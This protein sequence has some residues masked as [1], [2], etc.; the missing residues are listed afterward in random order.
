M[1]ALAPDMPCCA[2]TTEY[3][4]PDS[5]CMASKV[6]SPPV[7][8]VPRGWAMISFNEFARL[9]DDMRTYLEYEAARRHTDIGTVYEE[10]MAAEKRIREKTLRPEDLKALVKAS[11]LDTRLLDDDEEY[12]F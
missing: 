4:I 7:V 5:V 9:T 1:I 8:T 3:R 10:E 11:T 6:L 2:N 12:P